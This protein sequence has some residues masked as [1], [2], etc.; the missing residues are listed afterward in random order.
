MFCL[1]VLGSNF[2]KFFSYLKSMFSN[3]YD[4]KSVAKMKI[5]KFGTINALFGCLDWNLKKNNFIFEICAL[6]FI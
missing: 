5:L 6:E 3:L 4:A 1:D 2:E